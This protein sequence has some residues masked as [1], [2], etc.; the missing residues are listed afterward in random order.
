MP[1]PSDLLNPISAEKPCGE[2]LLYDKLF[3]EIK[4]ARREDDDVPSGDWART[5]KVADW[6]KTIK[7]ISTAL[8]TK[9][10]DLQLTAWLAEAML[11]R[12][13]IAGLREV[14]DLNRSLIETYWDTVWPELEDG[15][16]EFRAGKL[17]WIGDKLD[18]A[19]R[20]S[21]L[22]RSGLNWYQ[23]R[24]SRAV[25]SE[26]ACAESNEK[27]VTR[28]T[29]IAEGKVPPE[30]FDKDF[31]GSPKTFYANLEAAYEGTLESLALLG[32]ACDA[33]FGND[34]PSFATLRGTLEEVHQ[35]VHSL[36]QR[37]REKE[38]DAPVEAEAGAE[39]V[40]EE[41][42]AWEAPAATVRAA[43]PRKGGALTAEPVDRDDAVSR[44]V[45]AAR[46]LRQN[47]PYSPAA[48]MLL[49]GLRWGELRA[50]GYVDESL[51]APPPTEIRQKL[52]GLSLEG[53]W[54]EVLETAETAMG[55]ECGR[56][57]LDLQRYACRAC[58]ELGSYYE[59]IR[60]A[61]ISGL[62]ALLTDFAQLPDL[63]MLDDT[64]TANTETRTWIQEQVAAA[65]AAAGEAA[66]EPW[67]MTVQ[68]A[69]AHSGAEAGIPPPPDT[70]DLAMQAARAGRA[71]DG[72]ELLMREL[73]QER[74][75][76]G[77]F[78]RKVQL[79]QLCVSTSHENI[80]LPMLQE[81]AAE[82]DRRK[83]EDWEAPDMVASP[84]ALLHQ[85]LGK[86]GGDAGERARLYAWIC[87]LDPLMAL[88]LTR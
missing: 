58:Y 32:E 73:G 27:L 26:D 42:A 47:E 56:G 1:L 50:A 46:F 60:T 48:Y 25:P 52:K 19:V 80:A 55:L 39:V 78:H 63:T 67:G 65:P 29:L 43:A 38:P 21:A 16:A 37:K 66:P 9:T 11:R 2:N 71:Q 13:G 72:I 14:L 51:L 15:D 57:W 83:L 24:E 41:A 62:R 79:S 28:Q 54:S 22:T 49:R 35:T 53:N 87:R 88:K 86:S 5:R 10:K 64:P 76:R 82:I 23:F 85:C 40:E 18:R 59:P 77:R 8:T 33:K 84:L 6:P 12:E 3:D 44:V 36:L 17:Q 68:E 7:L 4:E 70:F 69:P 31:D 45:A 20:E 34:S 75:G 61:I 74:S 81:L 30:Q